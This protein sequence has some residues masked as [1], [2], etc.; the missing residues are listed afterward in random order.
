MY[1][2]R[3]PSERS[4]PDH[5]HLREGVST[6]VAASVIDAR[7]ELGECSLSHRASKRSRHSLTTHAGPRNAKHRQLLDYEDEDGYRG[8]RVPGP[9]PDADVEMYYDRDQDQETE[10]RDRKRERDLDGGTY[11]SLT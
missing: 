1:Q 4:S 7:R 8:G 2:G 6:S 5:S 3:A 10:L 11:I 9:G